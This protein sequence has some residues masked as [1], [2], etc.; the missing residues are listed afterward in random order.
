MDIIQPRWEGEQSGNE[1]SDICEESSELDQF[2]K[3]IT[4]PCWIFIGE[5]TRPKQE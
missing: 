5:S 1:G 3:T 2:N 4:S